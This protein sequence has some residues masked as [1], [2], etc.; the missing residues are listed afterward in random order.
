M[1]LNIVILAAGE[2]KRMYSSTPKVLHKVGG[3]PMLQHVIDVA[4]KL[5]PNKLIIVYGHKGEQVQS[6]INDAFKDNS[7]SW[8]Y[9]DKQLGTG[10]AL[11]MALPHLDST[12]AT[13]VLYG[14][15]PLINYKTLTK[16]LDS[17]NENV[18]MLTAILNDTYGYGR[19]LRD[20]T[21]KIIKVVE[22]KDTTDKEKDIKEINTGF[23]IFPNHLL[24]I[25]LN[26][27]SNDNQQ[28][29]YYLTD[30]VELAH[31]SNKL[32]QNI[33]TTTIYEIIGVNN[34]VQ[35]EQVERIYQG[36]LADTLLEKGVTLADKSRID[37]R[38]DISVGQDCYIDVNCVFEGNITLGNNVIIGVGSVLKNVIIS[39]GVC[40]KPYSIIEDAILGADSIIGPF[41]RIRPGTTLAQNTHIGNFVEVKNSK[42]GIGS[43]VNHLTYVGDA[44]IGSGVNVGAGSVTCNY[45][46]KNKFK[47]VI[48][49]GVFIGSGTMMVAPVTIKTGGV[50]GA[51]STITK[52]T[53]ENELTVSRAKQV[54]VLGWK[55]KQK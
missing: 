18:V 24:P 52:D 34:K 12:G 9:Q 44:E 19:I 6:T 28:K 16:M 45:D 49:D 50:I 29:E 20:E 11:K 32:I 33:A 48:E 26:Q 54:T 35:L 55:K 36:I 41:S 21:G 27:L 38:G 13:L 47:T 8:V 7:F 15:V 4:N 30:V 51:G 17:Y 37:I 25:W 46:G 22:E 5:N 14:D 40:I 23:Y 2:G 53:P 31:K 1:N 10:H 3:K 43:K 39:D 42:I